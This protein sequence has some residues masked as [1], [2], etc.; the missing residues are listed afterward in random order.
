MHLNVCTHLFLMP[1]ASE[2][3]ALSCPVIFISVVALVILIQG[4]KLSESD[5]FPAMNFLLAAEQDDSREG[6][7]C[8]ERS[9][10]NG[11]ETTA[12]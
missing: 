5:T 12:Q 11:Q 4:Y 2:M 3:L 9:R 8:A 1:N 10:W 7:I 6:R